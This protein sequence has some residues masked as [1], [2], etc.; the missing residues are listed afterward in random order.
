MVVVEV[1]GIGVMLMLLVKL[2][3][4][5]FSMVLVIDRVYRL[6]VRLLVCRLKVCRLLLDSL[7]LVQVWLLLFRVKL[8]MFMCER[9]FRVIDIRV[10]EIDVLVLL[11]LKVKFFRKV[12]LVVLLLKWVLKVD[13]VLVYIRVCVCFRFVVLVEDVMVMNVDVIRKLFNSF[14]IKDFFLV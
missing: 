10:E 5:E 2:L 1:F 12:W 14:F 8:L 4:V 11:M 3:F 7:V 9:L 13:V 6:E